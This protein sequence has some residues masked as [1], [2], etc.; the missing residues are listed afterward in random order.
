MNENDQ[1]RTSGQA[2]F[3]SAL[4]EFAEC[5]GGAKNS[6]LARLLDR[7]SCRDFAERVVPEGLVRLLLAAGLS[8]PTKSDLQQADVLWVRD[9]ALRAEVLEGI[10]GAHWIIHAPV[11]LVVCANGAR[12]ASLFEGAAF[13]ND[14]FDALFNATVDAAI[15]LEGIVAAAALA[16]LGTCPVSQL[17]NRAA[18]ISELLDL[19]DRVFPAAGLCLGY[20]AS[21]AP[22]SPR[23]DLRVT[24]HE[25][26]YDRDAF[27]RLAPAF[28]ARCI[29]EAPY[30]RQ[31]DPERFG[32]ADNYGWREDKRRQYADPQRADFGAFLRAKGF[33]FE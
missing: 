12:F 24:V 4:G 18:R 32:T 30:A 31:R 22:I 19:P 1:M 8:A 2:R 16:G 7:R 25:D 28:D 11:F 26:R 10:D 27:S 5:F 20:P 13:P 33:S 6:S 14:H 9:D 15:V 17:R 3:G 29:A 21:Q 23:L